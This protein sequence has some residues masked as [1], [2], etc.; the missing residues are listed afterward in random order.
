MVI[1]H[2]GVDGFYLV[3][4]RYKLWPDVKTVMKLE[5]PLNTRS[6]NFLSR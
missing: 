3:L 2:E 5:F 4:D 1:A 6:S